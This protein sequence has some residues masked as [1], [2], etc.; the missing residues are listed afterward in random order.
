ML[1]GDFHEQMENLRNEIRKMEEEGRWVFHDAEQRSS[2]NC[3]RGKASHVSAEAAMHEVRNHAHELR[4]DIAKLWSDFG[5]II[6]TVLE[7][8]KCEAVDARQK[9]AAKATEQLDALKAAVATT[10]KRSHDAVEH[11]G[12][13]VE[14]SPMLSVLGAF[15]IGLVIGAVLLRRGR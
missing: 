13:G 10:R 6:H 9:L 11:F 14:T 15:G 8:G 5:G 7:L 12:H 3:E 1:S 4:E 2:E